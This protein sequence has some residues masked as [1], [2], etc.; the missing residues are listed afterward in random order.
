MNSEIH[1]GTGRG[2]LGV[3]LAAQSDKGVCAIL[4]GESAP[5]LLADLKRRFPKARLARGGA[6]KAVLAVARAIE[7]PG[8]GFPFPLEMRGTPFQVAVWQ[9]LRTIPAGVTVS[10]TEV[11]R[12]VGR[13][14]AVRAV[15]GAIAANPLAVAVP[16]HRVISSSGGLGGYHWGLERKRALLRREGVL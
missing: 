2:D 16:C 8:G 4:L 10:Y 13:P 11:A 9:A 3:F 12:R 15:A 6:A 5:E 1:Y 14:D 7:A